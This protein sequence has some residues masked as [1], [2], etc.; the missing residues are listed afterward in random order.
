MKRTKEE[1]EKTRQ[2]ILDA[3][4]T[5]F[6]QTGYEAARLN[7]IATMADVTRGAIYHHFENKAGLF[8]ALVND[9]SSTGSKAI[10]AAVSEGGSFL[11]VMTR[12]LVFGMELLEEDQRFREIVAL[13]LLKTGESPE[14]SSYRERRLDESIRLVESI[15]GFFQMGLERG[16]IRADLDPATAARAFL[17][18]QSGLNVLWLSNPSAFS[19]KEQAQ[20]LA[21]IF[22]S[23]IAG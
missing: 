15:A 14:L 7:D 4:L 2:D 6:S 21:S 13:T 16:E 22:I 3:A 20:Q 1:A 12:I 8:M 11:D 18:Y 19:I 5:I 9:A 23:G 10:E 17:A